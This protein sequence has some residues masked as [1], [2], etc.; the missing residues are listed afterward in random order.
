MAL[1]I[2]DLGG[3]AIFLNNRC[4]AVKKE[5]VVHWPLISLAALVLMKLYN[6]VEVMDPSS[7]E[8]FMLTWPGYAKTELLTRKIFT[9]DLAIDGGTRQ[10]VISQVM[11]MINYVTWIASC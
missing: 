8:S 3:I 1:V 9:F 10:L 6:Y 4:D 2:E 5:K 7:T 11:A